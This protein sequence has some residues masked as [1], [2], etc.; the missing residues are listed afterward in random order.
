MVTTTA[1]RMVADTNW[2]DGTPLVRCPVWECTYSTKGDD[3]SH[4]CTQ[5]H[6]V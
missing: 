5:Y 2:F 3:Y 4:D 6:L 1:V